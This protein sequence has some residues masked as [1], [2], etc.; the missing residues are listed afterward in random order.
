MSDRWMQAEE[1]AMEARALIQAAE[2]FANASEKQVRSNFQ[3]LKEAQAKL[4]DVLARPWGRE[5]AV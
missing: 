2:Y 3:Q 5:D 4:N 1:D